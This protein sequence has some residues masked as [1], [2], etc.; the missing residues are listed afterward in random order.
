MPCDD[1]ANQKIYEAYKER[2]RA[3]LTDSAT[4]QAEERVENARRVSVVMYYDC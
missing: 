3:R 1:F 2:K 4:R